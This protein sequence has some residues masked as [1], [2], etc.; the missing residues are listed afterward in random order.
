[1]EIRRKGGFDLIFRWVRKVFKKKEKYIPQP[2]VEKDTKC[3][4][5]KY[6]YECDSKVNIT[7]LNDTRNHYVCGLG[8][9]CKAL[10][11]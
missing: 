3:D 10:E 1:M 6:K 2:Y 8:G 11:K 7:T 5:C 4:L 9:Y